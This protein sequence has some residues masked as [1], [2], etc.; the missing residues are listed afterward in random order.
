[1]VGATPLPRSLFESHPNVIHAN[2]RDA[3][4]ILLNLGPSLIN[5]ETSQRNFNPA[6]FK[7]TLVMV[8]WETP[9][10]GMDKAVLV[11][12][13][14]YLHLSVKVVIGDQSGHGS[15]TCVEESRREEG[16]SQMLIK[17]DAGLHRH[18][19]RRGKA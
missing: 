10:E 1:M 14:S 16:T 4:K 18:R 6:A 5:R 2:L 12:D 13:P 19:L 17:N 15:R 7:L 9:E 3:R 8:R 11:E